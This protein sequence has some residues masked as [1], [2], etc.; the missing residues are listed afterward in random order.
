MPETDPTA[1]DAYPSTTSPGAAGFQSCVHSEE[2]LS[3]RSLFVS[4]KKAGRSHAMRE[5]QRQSLPESVVNEYT[6]S[7]RPRARTLLTGL[8]SASDVS[9]ASEPLPAMS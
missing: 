3:P 7:E 1:R 8:P 6:Y 5:S 2:S 9:S 4:A